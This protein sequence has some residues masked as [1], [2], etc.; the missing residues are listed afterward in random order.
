MAE[1]QTRVAELEAEVLQL[2]ADVNK[3]LGRPKP[4]PPPPSKAKKATPKAQGDK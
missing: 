1:L 4:T 3:A 2:R